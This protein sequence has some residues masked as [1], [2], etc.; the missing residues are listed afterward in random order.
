M[1]T[2]QAVEIE[3]RP[4]GLR[5]SVLSGS[6][7]FVVN[8]EV[9]FMSLR[10]F[11]FDDGSDF[12]PE[13]KDN[14]PMTMI[15]AAKTIRMKN[16][17]AI[18]EGTSTSSIIHHYNQQNQHRTRRRST[19]KHL[20]LFNGDGDERKNKK[21]RMIEVNDNITSPSSDSVSTG[22]STEKMINK[23]KWTEEEHQLFLQG[24]EKY[25][26]GSWSYIASE[27]VKTRTQLQVRSHAQKHFAKLARKDRCTNSGIKRIRR[28]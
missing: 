20:I 12:D 24:M 7:R 16:C 22:T 15:T 2:Q 28:F 4:I 11:L 10:F 5:T 18:Q 8:D 27:L 1:V 13:D 23:G 25:G 21:Q 17:E 19:I 26:R 6:G 3:P 14:T 9:E